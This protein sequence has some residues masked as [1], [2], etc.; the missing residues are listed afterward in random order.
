[1]PRY[2]YGSL[3]AYIA[4]IS[5]HRCCMRFVRSS[6]REK[7]SNGQ[8]RER[9]SKHIHEAIRT[10][11]EAPQPRDHA[12]K[13]MRA[14]LPKKS[15]EASSAGLTLAEY[16]ENFHKQIYAL[17]NYYESLSVFLQYGWKNFSHETRTLMLDVFQNSSSKIWPLI[18]EYKSSIYGG[19]PPRDWASSFQ[20]WAGLCTT[21]LAHNAQP[22]I[23]PNAAR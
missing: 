6:K 8:P 7:D 18:N 14:R 2:I 13:K 12:A 11:R 19:E 20:W 5:S 21:R 4:S 15:A 22:I 23:P 9:E 10:Y 3:D 16:D 17:V 1:M